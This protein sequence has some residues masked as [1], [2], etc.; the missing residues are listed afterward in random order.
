ML[1]VKLLQQ[2]K[3]WILQHPEHLDMNVGIG[4][5][6]CGTVACIAGT[7]CMLSAPIDVEEILQDENPWFLWN[8]TALSSDERKEIETYPASQW[9]PIE[10]KAME[11]LGITIECSADKL[12]QLPD[13][14]ND[15]AH[16]YDEAENN[17][18]R[19]KVVA[20]YIDYYIARVEEGA[21][22]I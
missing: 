6:S 4:R 16:D 22:A 10:W 12:F 15:Y 7:A 1:N 8:E 20:D 3:E 17:Y 19:A 9:M 11:L 18:E 21:I 14:E 5:I 13:W 2:V